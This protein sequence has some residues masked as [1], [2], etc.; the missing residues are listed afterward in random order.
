[1]SVEKMQLMNIVGNLSELDEILRAMVLNG[2]LHFVNAIEEIDESDFT[3]SMLEENTQEIIDICL[4]KP[5]SSKSDF[6]SVLDDLDKLM[7]LMNIEREVAINYFDDEYKFIHVIERINEISLQFEHIYSQVDDFEELKKKLESLQVIGLLGKMDINFRDMLNMKNF[8]V[9]LGTL[10]NENRIK[11]SKNYENI[12]AIISHLGSVNSEEV[13]LV[14]F[15]KELKTETDR[16]LRSVYFAQ[17][18]FIDEVLDTPEEMDNNIKIRLSEVKS[19]IQELKSEI[20]SY[21][22]LYEEDIRASYS[23]VQMERQVSSIKS[24]VAVTRSFFYLSAWIPISGKSA[25]TECIQTVSNEYVIDYKDVEDVKMHTTPPTK[26][27]NNW[28]FKPFEYLVSMYGTPSYTEIDP[29]IFLGITYM[30]LFGAMFGDLGQ[31]LVIFIGGIFIAKKEGAQL[32]GGILSRIGISSMFFG[33]FYDSFFG[34]EH[35]ISHFISE[36]LNI[37]FMENLFIRPIEN[38]NTVLATSIGLGVLLLVISFIYSIYNKLKLGD[39]KEGVF[40]RNGIF[41]LVLYLS[42]LMFVLNKVLSINYIPNLI[43]IGLI[44]ISIFAL[45]FREPISN[46]ILKH[47]PLYHESAS[48]YY[49]ESGFDLLETFL[50]MLSNSVSFIRVGAFALNHVGLFIAFHTMADLMGSGFGQVLMFFVGN[51]IVIFLEGLIVLIQGLRLVYYELFSKYYTGEGILYSPTR[52][53]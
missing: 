47:K 43:L 25:F 23:R 27:N 38:I 37:G 49:V 28:L 19:K 11:L 2:N 9:V 35:I 42:L 22:E 15:P 46:L 7:D 50:S 36:T 18:E 39:I 51:L 16:I 26:L 48:E 4:I 3:L 13:L 20:S 53:I 29:S 8:E 17:I 1:M 40:G 21:K 14:V 34:Y 12:P 41:G 32:Y 5:F 52:L 6:K 33:F 24:L 45:I 10:S 44:I 31:G 30:L